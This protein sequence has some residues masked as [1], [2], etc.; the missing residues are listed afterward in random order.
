MVSIDAADSDL[1]AMLASMSVDVAAIDQHDGGCKTTVKTRNSSRLVDEPNRPRV[2]R[3]IR[4][5][6]MLTRLIQN[7]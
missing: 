7:F 4:R 2:P 1:C 5:D 6:G 3:S